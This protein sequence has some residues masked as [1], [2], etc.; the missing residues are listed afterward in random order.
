MENEKTGNSIDEY[1]IEKNKAFI[2]K[3]IKIHGNKYDYTNVMY[4]DYKKTKVEII[5]GAHKKPLSFYQLPSNHLAGRGCNVCSRYRNPEIR[6]I[7]RDDFIEKAKKIHCDKYDYSDVVYIDYETKVK[8]KCHNHD[9]LVIFEQAPRFHLEGRRCIK[10]AN[11][12]T[13]NKNRSTTEEFINKAKKIH[14]DKYDYSYVEYKDNSTKIQIVCNNHSEPIIFEQRPQTHLA[15]SGCQ[16]CGFIISSEKQCMT[17]Q[18]FTDKAIK[19]HGNKY[20]YNKV[21]YTDSRTK[22]IISCPIHNDFYQTPNEHLDRSGCKK[23]GLETI[24]QK[25]SSTRDEFIKKATKVHGDL[26]DYSKVKYINS[27]TKV[28]IGCKIMGHG[29]FSQS[30][31]CHLQKQGCPKCYACPTCLLWRTGGVLCE[32]C[33]PLQKNKL[34]EKTKEM[35][36]VK[37]LKENLPDYEFIHNKSVGTECSDGHLFPDIRFDCSYYHLI[38]EIDEHELRGANYEC[39]KRRMYDIIAKLGLPC[40]FIRYNPDNKNSDLHC[41]LDVIKKYIDLTI[42]ESKNMFDNY[43]FKVEYL[44]YKKS[45][46]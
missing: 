25:N 13:S 15:G 43:G 28:V 33:K 1:Q 23:C 37:F 40:I 24:R 8:I 20:D 27:S 11:V 46:E 5:C 17:K 9:K 22:I 30:P 7:T 2:D 10:C 16:K 41:L 34:Y 35:K 31:N 19:I 12:H 6:K 14:G 18:E 21:E 45:V 44:F 36:V 38:I 3:A 32:Y 26:Y 42:D 29:D 4:K 39:D